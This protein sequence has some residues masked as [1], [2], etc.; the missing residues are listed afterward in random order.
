M[1]NNF[2]VIHDALQFSAK[3][4]ASVFFINFSG[5]KQKNHNYMLQLRMG[6]TE[7]EEFERHNS[8]VKRSL[9]TA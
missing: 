6:Y 2:F 3:K 7:Y 4:M 9:Y 8:V 5:F 1:Y